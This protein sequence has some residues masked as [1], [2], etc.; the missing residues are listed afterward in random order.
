LTVVGAYLDDDNGADS[1]SAYVYRFNGSRWVQEQ[2]LLAADGAMGDEFGQS[3]SVGGNVS[4]VGAYRDDDNGTDS[5]SAYIYRFNGLAWVQEQELLATDGATGDRFG[6]SVSVGGDTAVVGA[7]WDDDNGD[8]SGSAYIYRFNGSAWVQEQ[9][10]L[11]SDGAAGDQFGHSVS[12]S[13]DVAV[14][15]ACDDDDNGTGSGS[16][17]VF[18]FNG[19]T[20]VQ[21]Q[22][23]LAADGAAGDL[24][25]F[26]V[27]VSGDDAV[28]GAVGNDDLGS[29]SGSAYVFSVSN[30]CPA[31]TDCDGA[32]NVMDLLELLASW[33]PCPGCPA[34]TNG[35]GNVN[36]TDFLALLAGWGACP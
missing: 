9:N 4:V 13:G 20:W 3:V 23:L 16:A 17:Y 11:P 36:V 34:D 30:D 5:G 1:G 33:G 6:I 24:L 21:E 28:V 8:F 22:K 15:G 29:N 2:K 31:D 25:G 32:V 27:S 19:A 10:L 14:V 7:K 26:T 35:D 18:R 12:I